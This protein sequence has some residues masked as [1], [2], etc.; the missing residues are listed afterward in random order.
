MQKLT[1]FTTDA[2]QQA[3]FRT[4]AGDSLTL[5]LYY[6]RN[7]K[8][9][10]YDLAYGDFTVYGLR[11]VAHPNTLLPYN[12][13]LPFGLAVVTTQRFD[14]QTIAALTNGTVDLY[15]LNADEV[16]AVQT[17]IDEN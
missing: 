8:S 14:P 12:N 6:R 2:K 5:T 3:T 13:I 15:L 1:G 16:V 7:Q 10:F 17:D 11:L 4:E 9:W